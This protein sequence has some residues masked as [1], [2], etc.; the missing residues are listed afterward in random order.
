[1]GV[2]SNFV[3]EREK[4]GECVCAPA[5]TTCIDTGFNKYKVCVQFQTW[6]NTPLWFDE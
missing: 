1:M 2:Q 4:E 5:Y 6:H 3:F